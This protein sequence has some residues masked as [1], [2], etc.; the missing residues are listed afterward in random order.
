MKEVSSRRALVLA[1][2]FYFVV[3]RLVPFGRTLLYPLTLLATFVHEMGHGLTALA[4]GGRFMSLDI[5]ANGSGLAHTVT[6]HPWQAGATAAGGL[7]APPIFGA[8]V[9]AT[10]GGPR[11]ARAILTGLCVTILL[12]LA[13]WVRSVTGFVAL[14]LV[15]AVLLA[16][17]Y[18]RWGTPERRMVFAQLI[19]I[20]IA[21]DTASRADYLLTREV[22]IDGTPRKSDIV[23]VAEAFGGHY[24]VWGLAIGA[25]SFGL[26]SL[27][28]WLAWRSRRAALV[29][30]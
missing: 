22:L 20:I 14:P 27:G 10:S 24:L 18:T 21:L 5:Y 15:A 3:S 19:G 6:L 4:T 25:L 13:I 1:I 8:S 30:A 17:L 23:T 7:L 11:R 29:A 28:L 26:L 16:L 9:L 12:S 2:I